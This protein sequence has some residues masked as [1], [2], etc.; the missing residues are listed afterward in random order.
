MLSVYSLLRWTC[1]PSFNLQLIRVCLYFSW[2]I[3]ETNDT[4]LFDNVDDDCVSPRYVA[5]RLGDAHRLG[6]CV[7][8]KKNVSTVLGSCYDVSIRRFLVSMYLS[9]LHGH[10]QASQYNNSLQLAL[11]DQT[12]WTMLQLGLFLYELASRRTS[13]RGG[14]AAVETAGAVVV[15]AQIV[16]Y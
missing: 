9:Y 5:Y 10:E 14:P 2:W 4:I 8:V 3:L 16:F 11:F 7:F 6:G 1:L 15:G 13:D 12:G